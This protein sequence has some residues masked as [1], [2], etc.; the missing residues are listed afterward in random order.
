[1]L[2]VV[3]IDADGVDP[4]RVEPGADA[5]RSPDALDWLTGHVSE[6]IQYRVLDRGT[7]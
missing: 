6:A 7:Q 5:E 4:P 1:V 3:V 2:E